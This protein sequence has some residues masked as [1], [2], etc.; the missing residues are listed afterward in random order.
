MFCYSQPSISKSNSNKRLEVFC[1]K[2]LLKNFVKLIPSVEVSFFR[3][4]HKIN[5]QKICLVSLIAPNLSQS[6][7]KSS[8]PSQLKHLNQKYCNM[9]L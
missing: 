1:K 2:R 9:I 4:E 3:M 5:E 7:N 6:L 8:Y